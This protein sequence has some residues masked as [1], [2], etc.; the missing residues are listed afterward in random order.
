MTVGGAGQAE[1]RVVDVPFDPAAGELLFIP[2]AAELKALPSH[3]LQVRLVA[4][5][6]AGERPLGEYTFRHSAS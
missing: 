3:V 2:A 1:E 4:V 5:E 6:E